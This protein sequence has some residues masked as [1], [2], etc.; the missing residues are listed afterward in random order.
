M[1]RKILVL[2]LG[3]CFVEITHAQV[4]K[5]I[6]ITAGGLSTALTETEKSTVTNL[7]ITG[8][9]DAR[10]FKTMR[11]DMPLLEGIDIH[12][13]SISAYSGPEGTDL[14]GSTIAPENAIP[15]S[16]F[17]NLKNG[18]LNG[19]T[20]LTKIILPSNLVAFGESSFWGSGLTSI[21]IPP[22][23][24]TIG[25][26]AFAASR[27]TTL[28]IPSSVISIGGY[29]F[30]NC[31]SLSSVII[32]SS[33]TYIGAEAFAYSPA[34]FTVDVNNPMY[35]SLD[36]VLLNKDQTSIIQFPTSR[37]G[38]Y[39]IPNSVVTIDSWSFGGCNL[40]SLVLP[41][42]VKSIGGCA[43]WNGYNISTINLPPSLE[44]IGS[45]AFWNCKNLTSIMIPSS[46]KYIGDGAF[47]YCWRLLSVTIPLTVEYIGSYAFKDCNRL[48]DITVGWYTPFELCPI[49]D[50]AY[51]C[52][53]F[54]GVDKN[55]C[56]L[57]VPYGTSDLYQAANEWK[58]FINILEMPGGFKIGAYSIEFP[59]NASTSQLNITSD[60]TWTT[61]SDSEWLKVNPISG[62]GNNTVSFSV[63]SNL[64]FV[65]RT[66]KVIVSAPNVPT[67]TITI[68]QN[69][70][71]R[72]ANISAGGL[73]NTF[74]PA[75]LKIV[76]SM[77]INGTI[78]ARDFRT[79]RDNMPALTKLDLNGV[80]VIAYTG[81]EGTSSSNS[82]YYP[83]NTLPDHAFYNPNTL[84]SKIDISLITLPSGITTIGDSCFLGC[85][86]LTQ[87]DIP[88]T[89]TRIRSYAFAGCSKLNSFTI[90][91]SVTIIDDGS[92][93]NCIGLVNL[94]ISTAVTSI[95]E[96]AFYGCS[97]LTS[98]TIPSS[99]IVIKDSTF[100]NCTGLN[101]ISIPSG[102][103][104][105]GNS[106][107]SGCSALMAITF[108][109]AVSFIGGH[110]F[111]DCS[112][113][114]SIVIP[115]NLA[116][117]GE[118]A[119]SGCKGLTS[120]TIPASITVIKDGT[121]SGCSGLN[122]INL[123]S[124]VMSIGAFAFSG[125][126]NLT[127]LTLPLKITSI[128][129]YAFT[130]CGGLISVTIPPLVTEIKDGT[131]QNCNKLTNISIP[132][133][134][135]IIGN[136]AFSNCTGLREIN[137]PISV[138]KIGT[139]AFAGCTALNNII[140][141]SSIN[142]IELGTFYNFTGLAN[143]EIPSSVINIGDMAFA[144]CGG[145]KTVSIPTSVLF[146]GGHAFADCGL[147]SVTL[148][149]KITVLW[150]G[151]FINCLNLRT[152]I[153]PSS[154]EIIQGAFT[155][156]I[157]LTTIS[158]P[159]T[160]KFLNGVFSDCI[161]LTTIYSYGNEPAYC[162]GSEFSGVDKTNCIVYV[163]FGTSEIY[164][165][166]GQ[167]KDFMNIIEMPGFKISTSNIDFPPQG[168]TSQVTITSSIPWIASSDKDWLKL[169]P[170]SGTG[171]VTVNITAET[172]PIDTPR[173]AKVTVS[174]SGVNSQ[175]ITIT[176]QA[177]ITNHIPIA[178]AGPDK[179]VNHGNV[180]MLDGSASTDPDGNQLTYLWT[181]PA[182]VILSATNISKPTFTA[183]NVTES[184]NYT[185]T[186]V[187][188][189]G[190]INSLP[191]Q[192][193]ITVNG[194]RAPTE[195]VANSPV[196]NEI[197]DATKSI[198]FTWTLS[199]DAD[200]DLVTYKLR[201]WNATKDTTIS[202]L[203]NTTYTLPGN[204]LMGHSQ[205]NY[206]L[207]ASDGKLET[208][209]N[210]ANFKTLN[211]PPDKPQLISPQSYDTPDASLEINFIWTE[212]NDLDKDVITYNLRIWNENK[213]IYESGPE[214]DR[215][216]T[217]PP[218][219]LNAGNA[220]G[221]DV[222]ASDGQYNIQTSLIIF[223][224]KSLGPL[225][226]GIPNI[227]LPVNHSNNVS[228]PVVFKWV[229]E[230]AI[231]Y[232][233]VV[234]RDQNFTDIE[235]NITV[236][237][238]D[239]AL[240]LNGNR[241]Y[242]YKVRGY[243]MNG[244]GD[245]SETVVFETKNN[246]PDAFQFVRPKM[247]ELIQFKN[248]KLEIETTIPTD[249]DNDILTKRIRITGADIDT[250]I[251]ITGSLPVLYLE[252]R[253]LRSNSHYILY[254]D[255]T[256]GKATTPASNNTITFTTPVYTDIEEID[257][258]LGLTVYPNPVLDVMNI[259]TKGNTKSTEYIILNSLGLMVYKGNIIEKA[260]VQTSSF[261]PDVYIIKLENGK[262]FRFIKM[263]QP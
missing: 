72:V 63:D 181:E 136:N 14:H 251:E 115:S 37:T 118:Y 43:F 154:I 252:A 191:D 31:T 196:N 42:S 105:I 73:A 222:V 4:Y 133:A 261:N 58:E 108:P 140:I 146:I 110:A 13:S 177:A 93:R 76:R 126:G 176:Q 184:T 19:K 141:P 229:S 199:T 60:I 240:I 209:S 84:I 49:E 225:M 234:S 221:W 64:T 79:I 57:H 100:K 165:N 97:G 242:Y 210:N 173:N 159:S 158:L 30:R 188:N 34:I 46:V 16:A 32:P 147:I 149:D 56:K 197:K 243:N 204:R 250:L 62:I 194:N 193:I 121:F 109:S 214:L 163:P 92:F 25:T 90:P 39:T 85:I 125:C 178:D 12:E 215:I 263:A 75:E 224:T 122:S 40:S 137:V 138:S 213:I 47:S 166:A 27:I 169:N 170:V 183:P 87:I 28:I 98:I 117:L 260:V 21:D 71:A 208:T 247:D 106:A 66:A 88:L 15:P 53:I 131:F 205:Y 157:S 206:S 91:S 162:F 86:G 67:K 127:S 89:V 239:T 233:L 161:G 179:T 9:I 82:V 10:D 24:I 70:F 254:G 202:N 44:T 189:D 227:V 130:S 151:T 69:E 6:S 245:W 244:L 17:M 192:V 187:V 148:P 257:E 96:S 237:R 236:F 41:N 52:F 107:F 217:L 38:N 33:V 168:S 258:T 5:S 232:D 216:F 23:V 219:A 143:V 116:S 113:L 211:H 74:S 262:T 156:C 120:V 200:G 3:L 83:G 36:G 255:V 180:V 61:S 104:F 238:S 114:T 20:S 182:G 248:G 111:S 175:Q 212:S 223:N 80:N 230:N 29:A 68:T 152:V 150:P 11:D 119:F 218:N 249:P 65:V 95:G 26:T 1:K 198:A 172:N 55:A 186:L 253:F 155:N 135:N 145:L 77:V 50:L 259:E 51:S 201:I 2:L 132:F 142:S 153:L 124:D 203:T 48:S 160:L 164:A 195:P 78:D 220:Y 167:W 129:A 94:S 103:T 99:V 128:G 207:T 22:S 123:S 139:Y 231:V 18:D 228:V 7:T 144:R 174:A 112:N 256:D 45:D 171:N 35:S 246:P 134:I 190:K 81:T 226:P 235:T 54:E 102:I 59:P 8:T 241:T 185:F 101:N